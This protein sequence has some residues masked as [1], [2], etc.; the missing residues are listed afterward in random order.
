[1]RIWTFWWWGA[2]CSNREYN[3]L[4]WKFAKLLLLEMY[5]YDLNQGQEC[6]LGLHCNVIAQYH[7][8]LCW[9]VFDKIRQAVISFIFS[10]VQ[11]TN[12]SS[13]RVMWKT[14]EILSQR[15]LLIQ[16]LFH[17]CPGIC[18]I[19]NLNNMLTEYF[20]RYNSRQAINCSGSDCL[21]SQFV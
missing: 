15:F 4:W 7:I 14:R 19:P 8:T 3:N 12:C 6:S 9:S 17:Q 18:Q 20:I 1:M 13:T 21:W 16:L 5:Y 2:I 11:I 10:T